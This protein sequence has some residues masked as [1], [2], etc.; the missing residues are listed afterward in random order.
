MSS[1]RLKSKV[2]FS[3]IT[4][5]SFA[6]A[7]VLIVAL[8]V[9]INNRNKPANLNDINVIMSRVSLLYL[10]PTDE[11]PALATV[12]DSSKLTSSFANKVQNGDKILFYE[13][14]NKAIV[15]RPSINKI[16]TVEPIQ[17]DSVDKFKKS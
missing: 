6:L 16:V 1:L 8:L 5:L 10:M 4:I 9:F 15:Y 2:H 3:K 17:I 7:I 13:K 14:N 12:T 11:E